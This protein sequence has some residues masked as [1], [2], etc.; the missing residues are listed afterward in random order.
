MK[1]S[2]VILILIVLLVI[3]PAKF[4]AGQSPDPQTPTDVTST[5]LPLIGYTPAPQELPLM[6]GIYPAE[7]INSQASVDRLIKA[8][9]TWAGKRHSLVGLF[10]DLEDAHPEW[11]FK[12]QMEYLWTNGYTPFVN[13]NSTRTAS[14][15]A[16][17]SIDAAIIN[18]GKSYA[19]WIALGGGRK[20]FL[21]PL[22]EMNGY[23]TSY[24]QDITNYKVSYNRI[25][26]I[27]VT[28]GAPL[29]SAWWTFAPNGYSA[30]G[31]EF[32]KFYPGD[33]SVDALGFSSYNYGYCAIAAPYQKWEEAMVLYDSYITRMRTMAP[34]KPIIIAQTGT[35]AK[36]PNSNTTN[37]AKKDQWLLN[38]YSYLATRQG[39]IGVMYYDLDL[40]WECDWAIFNTTSR[41][42][43]YQTIA[44]WTDYSYVDPAVLS[45]MGLVVP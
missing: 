32:E 40:S 27:F 44:T 17:G 7:G 21:A 8:A 36:Y 26:S 38:T 33:A 24:G 16:G 41:Y 2:I 19:E 9:D 31:Y 39:V 45:R 28:Q 11:D 18:M 12:G 5:F 15:I 13:L 22:Q 4:T 35:S 43:A 25:R 10:V 6:L 3:S 23:W 37:H 29:N 42:N 20:A 34:T 1:S 14:Q 30:K